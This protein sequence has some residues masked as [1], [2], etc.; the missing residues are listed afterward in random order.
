M[1]VLFFK[2]N[3][4]FVK[5]YVNS[6]SNCVAFW[7]SDGLSSYLLLSEII[8][9]EK[10]LIE[11]KISEVFKKQYVDVFSGIHYEVFP[12]KL[13]TETEN[14]GKIAFLASNDTHIHL[15]KNILKRIGG[16]KYSLYC[17][18]GENAPNEASKLG[19][20]NS[21]DSFDCI[22]SRHQMNLL[23]LGND[24]G[25]IEYMTVNK[26]HS[27]GVNTVCIQESILDLNLKDR[28][29]QNCSFPVFQGLNTLKS[30]N[31][32]NKIAAIIGNPRFEELQ[33]TPIP[34]LPK[35]FI[36]VNF[37]YGIFEDIRDKWLGDVLTCC[38][39][40]KIDYIISQHPRDN[41]KLDGLKVLK[42]NAGV[43]HDAIKESSIVVSRFSAILLEA[44]ALGRP[45]IYY[46]P[47]G[48]VMQYRFEPDNKSLFF[49]RDHD[50]LFEIIAYLISDKFT[51]SGN[52]FL[53]LHLGNTY[54]GTSSKFISTLLED[55]KGAT[56]IKKNSILQIIKVK[57]RFI[58]FIIFNKLKK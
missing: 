15:F 4:E 12:S 24:W 3:V 22:D 45:A 31:L 6:H 44:I 38:A 40:L 57:L 50:S 23:V 36:N 20:D 46:N 54:E 5:K 25:L 34:N 1:V 37:T 52:T 29:L 14:T 53:N 26:Y 30:V 58:K 49:A 56:L 48:E 2:N 19:F 8:K 33:P 9:I 21:G 43:V 28:R 39:T 32:E 51:F 10:I 47:H 18:T 27:L 16:S 13:K 35:V 42:S 7:Y 11:E 41:G 55:I 17:R